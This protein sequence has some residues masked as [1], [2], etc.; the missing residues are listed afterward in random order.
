MTQQD[1]DQKL[2]ELAREYVATPLHSES[3]DAVLEQMIGFAWQ[4]TSCADTDALRAKDRVVVVLS[5]L[6]TR[7]RFGEDV[8][9]HP[10]RYDQ[11][12]SASMHAVAQLAFA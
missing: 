1:R 9:M 4:M 12:A 6:L 7:A 11:L 10:D 5:D 3:A 8:E 2:A